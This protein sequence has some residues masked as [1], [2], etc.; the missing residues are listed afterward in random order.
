MEITIRRARHDE[1][2]LV[3]AF[4]KKLF[5]SDQSSDGD[6]DVEW[7]FG[8]EGEAFYLSRIVEEDALCLIALVDG[9]PAGFVC[10]CLKPLELWRPVRRA[11]LE[12]LFIRSS[13][14]S[15]GIGAL[16]WAEFRKWSVSMGASRILVSVYF[17]NER[18]R[19]FYERVGFVPQTIGA[20]ANLEEV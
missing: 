3:Q 4:A 20:E 18:A 15:H 11:E 2:V 19:R 9:E 5:L 17:M 14:R 16:M 10:G 6:L 7:P 12:N 8:E 1:L 13:H